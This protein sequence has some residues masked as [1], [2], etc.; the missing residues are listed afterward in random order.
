MSPKRKGGAAPKPPAQPSKPVATTSKPSAASIPPFQSAQGRPSQPSSSTAATSS[1]QRV[2][3]QPQAGPSRPGVTINPNPVSASLKAPA[4]PSKPTAQP[5]KSAFA[6]HLR[7]VPTSA[8]RTGGPQQR[9]FTRSD[10][11]RAEWR[12]FQEKWV[13]VYQRQIER[14]LEELFR[15]AERTS[16]KGTPPSG[17]D[18]I[19]N[20]MQRDFA[21]AARAEW[22]ARLARAQL[23]AEDWT[24]MTLEEMME[25]EQVLAYEEPEDEPGAL[26]QAHSHPTA[27]P[28]P[29]AAQKLSSGQ[30]FHNTQPM[31][32]RYS[33]PAAA[34]EKPKTSGRGSEDV[35]SQQHKATSVPSSAVST[36]RTAPASVKT[37][38][39]HPPPATSGEFLTYAVPVCLA[40]PPLDSALLGN[41]EYMDIV[42][43]LHF[44]SIHQF[45]VK[46]AD[47]DAELALQLC[48]PMP[49]ADREFTIRA[50]QM[51]MEQSA[52][53]IVKLRDHLL[54]EERKKRGLGGPGGDSAPP[55]AATVQPRVE[56]QP[57]APAKVETRAPQQPPGAFPEERA[58]RATRRTEPSL[59]PEPILE[60]VPDGAADQQPATE[61]EEV[62]EVI[63]IP[64]KGKG[65]KKG[66]KAAVVETKPATTNS[67]STPTPTS[68]TAR[69]ATPT[70]VKNAP[71]RAPSPAPIN[72]KLAAAVPVSGRGTP[73]LSSSSLSAHSWGMARAESSGQQALEA[74]GKAKE[75]RSRAREAVTEGHTLMA[76][77]GVHGTW[78]PPM[79]RATSG[80]KNPFAPS[81]PSRLAQVT[82]VPDREL[83]PQ[84]PESPEPPSPPPHEFTGR[85][86]VAW[87]A[88]SSSE[89]E[90]GGSGNLLDEDDDEED[91]EEEASGTAGFGGLL[92]SLAGASPWALFGSENSQPQKG[93]AASPARGRGA[94]PTPARVPAMRATPAPQAEAAYAR[95]GAPS[96]A[97]PSGLAAAPSAGTRGPPGMW[98]EEGEDLDQMLEIASSALDTAATGRGRN[99]MDMEQAMA[100]FIAAS[101]A[102]ETLATPVGGHTAWGR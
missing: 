23:Q 21:L 32:S 72:T 25:V 8:G 82:H 9:T 52:R 81:R 77:S 93:R 13:S 42:Y 84:S 24:D 99:G 49:T 89:D 37:A 19:V 78:T 62:D 43:K 79:D 91:E 46:A 48:K 66:K 12:E 40:V 41:S 92:A 97:G 102:R 100:M 6:S 80:S 34:P 73:G 7:S 33:P 88:G 64:I 36:S 96:N 86:Y 87:F 69:A 26:A 11:V 15:T 67:R 71:A 76:E 56:P 39:T 1:T 5:A 30:P 59:D 90:E 20:T 51:A 44:N 57:Q 29:A 75:V 28:Q 95:W 17:M 58:Q 83:I 18:K 85:D 50:H 2:S 31:A 63:E 45:H 16:R 38:Q 101:K 4:Q 27:P 94:T 74:K 35:R 3:P 10:R 98:K 22:D 61:P 47:A 68:S 54:Q 14:E 55:Q 70:V 60:Y 53:D 65:K